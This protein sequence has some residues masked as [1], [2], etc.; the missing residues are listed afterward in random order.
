MSTTPNITVYHVTPVQTIHKGPKKGCTKCKK[1]I[2]MDKRSSSK[3]GKKRRRAP[4]APK[5]YC[6]DCKKEIS[7]KSVSGYCLSC[8]RERR[9]KGL[10]IPPRK[11][12]EAREEKFCT[13]C[14]KPLYY[15]NKTGLCRTCWG[16]SSEAQY[17]RQQNQNWVN[18][19]VFSRNAKTKQVEEG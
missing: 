8:L 14:S 13:G 19:A 11:K 16:E 15:N 12:R 10:Y 1:L 5:R 18:S 7:K 17:Q 4:A 2:A 6:G 3:G 9:A